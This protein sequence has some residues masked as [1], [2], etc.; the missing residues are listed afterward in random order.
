MHP[1]ADRDL[2]HVLDHTRDLWDDFRGE[3][4]FITGGTGFFGCW[5]LETFL[6]ANQQLNLGSSVTVLSRSPKTFLE[7]MPHL[8][9][10][11]EIQWI[12]GD[13]VDFSFPAGNFPFVIHAAT[14]A[15]AKLT[16]ENPQKMF[17]TIVD[18]TRRTIEFAESHA[19]KKFLLTSS[20]A[21]YGKQP[22]ELERIPEDYLGAPSPLDPLAVYGE[23]KRAAEMLCAISSSSCEK[24][25]ARCFAFVGPHLPLDAHF[26]IGNFIRDAMQGGPI[27][28]N[29]DGTPLRSYLYASDL[30]IWLWTILIKGQHLRP[31]NVGSEEHISIA[32]LAKV[33]SLQVNPH[34]SVIMKK[35]S[36]PSKPIDK[37]IPDVTLA[38]D[39]L[40]LDVEVPLEKSILYTIEYKYDR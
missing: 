38:K 24:K 9:D 19:T 34:V 28:I 25:I 20:G 22:P 12:Q 27:K 18:G 31:Y 29:G 1:L 3:R 37:Y 30:A 15:S 2:N 6:W 17:D 4:V 11:K 39:E 7:R 33:V 26:A 40:F 21:I 14:E 32:E 36:D 23:G 10:R 16:R 35:I 5:L 13:V 8:K